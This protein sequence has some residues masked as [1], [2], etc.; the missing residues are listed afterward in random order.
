M[1]KITN[2]GDVNLQVAHKIYSNSYNNLPILLFD[3]ND[4]PC[5]SVYLVVHNAGLRLGVGRLRQ[6]DHLSLVVLLQQGQR[7][8]AIT[9]L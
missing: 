9:H 1:K 6:T 8:A 3:I 7:P 5:I 2:G 4:N